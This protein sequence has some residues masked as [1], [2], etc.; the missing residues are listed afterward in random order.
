M[1]TLIAATFAALMFF[2]F[3]MA[4]PK[5]SEAGLNDPWYACYV[6]QGGTLQKCV[7]PFNNQYACMGYQYSIPY[8]ARWLGCKQ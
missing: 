2:A 7:G 1:K 4:I 6:V 8:G 5:S 3:E